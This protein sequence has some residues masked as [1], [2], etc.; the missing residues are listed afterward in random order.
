MPGIPPLK[1]NGT[2]EYRHP[3]L[4]VGANAEV[5]AQQDRVDRFEMPTAAFAVF[6]LYAQKELSSD[7]IRHSW[8]L[9]LDNMANTEYRNHL[10]RIRSVMPESG[11][12]LRLNYRIS[13]F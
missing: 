8:T 10:S 2:L 11:R 5:A 13:Y 12:N 9:T 1:V 4:T 7:Q 6:G 3:W